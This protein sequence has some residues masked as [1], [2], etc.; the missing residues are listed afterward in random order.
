MMNYE[1]AAANITIILYY[2]HQFTNYLL[3]TKQIVNYQLSIVNC[4]LSIVN[5]Q[6]SIVNYIRVNQYVKERFY[7]AVIYSL[8]IT[9]GTF[10]P[11]FIL[12]TPKA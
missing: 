7:F 2:R 10:A 12:V 6:L 4:Q 8:G 11:S 5:C 9:S 3:H 1:F